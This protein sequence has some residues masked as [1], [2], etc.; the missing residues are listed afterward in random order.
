[1]YTCIHVTCYATLYNIMLHY[2][3]RAEPPPEKSPASRA[4]HLPLFGEA[5]ALK[6]HCVL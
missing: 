5:S 3:T 4:G 2:M 6:L 1:M